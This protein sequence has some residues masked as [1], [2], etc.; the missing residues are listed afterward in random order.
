MINALSN[1]NNRL[2]GY[3]LTGNCSMFLEIE[4]VIGFLYPCQKKSSPLKYLIAVTT[5]FQSFM[6]ETL[7]LLIKLRA[8]HLHL[9]LK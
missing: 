2:V 3:M 4:G 8:K 1:K 5:L 9:L 7:W 6:T